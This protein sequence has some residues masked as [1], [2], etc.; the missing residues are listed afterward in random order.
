MKTSETD[1]LVVGGSLV[2]LAAAMFLSWRGVRV[3]LVEK[4][5]GSSAHP[6]AV[7]YTARTMELL[8]AVGI[9]DQ[10]PAAPEGFRLR[11]I[12]VE[13][14][15]GKWFDESA[16]TDDGPTVMPS[17]ERGA[18]VAQDHLEPLMRARAIELGAD[19]RLA[20][21]LVSFRQD[22]D[23]VTAAVR[24]RGGEEASIHAKYMIAADGTRSPV[25]EQLGI[26]R[27]G[28]GGMR[29]LRSVLFKA[30]LDEYLASG[31]AQFQINQPDF[32]AFLTTYHDGRWVL[33]LHDDREHT[34]D[35][36]LAAI[37]RALGRT[38]LP[39]EILTTG[40]WELSA[41]IAD[42]F[43]E[44]RV[45]LAGDAAHTLP[46]SRGG[47]GAN[48]GIEDAHNLAW[49]LAAVLDGTAG[50]RL[51]ETY[52]AE[53]RPI[54]WLRH[55]QIFARQ[56][57]KAEA[58]GHGA[59]TIYPDIAL[60]LGQLYRS[61]AVI[62][63]SPDLPPAATPDEWCGQPGTRAPHL[64][65]AP[66]LS[67]LDVLQR[68]WVV[69]SDDRRWG[70]QTVRIDAKTLAALGLSPGG[71]ALVRPDGYIAWRSP[72]FASPSALADAIATCTH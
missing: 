65:L 29:V 11:R 33:F 18:A 20:T 27:T 48:T 55:D 52:D 23:G 38:D 61:S 45:F 70:A 12:R 50:S 71:A 9:A 44:G 2:G 69:L 39:I 56:D 43:T 42:R 15:A 41:L 32:Q 60:E 63:A 35:E 31:I 66:T 68:G 53:R 21:E 6:R 28:R 25:R 67:L 47:F 14:L 1:V 58:A 59:T 4:H 49:K 24:P 10:V 62:G 16:W 13:S 51:L 64:W 30:P 19:V 5:A 8:R 72:T 34:N 26:G 22:A 54:A 7:G 3:T 37:H 40:R 36:L 46:P 57:Y 17:P